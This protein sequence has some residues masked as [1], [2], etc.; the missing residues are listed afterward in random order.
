MRIWMCGQE[1]EQIRDWQLTDKDAEHGDVDEKKLVSVEDGDETSGRTS[2]DG[3]H[4][5]DD[6]AVDTRTIRRVYKTPCY[7]YPSMRWSD[8]L[9]TRPLR[10]AL[11]PS[12]SCKRTA[13]TDLRR[14]QQQLHH[15]AAILQVSLGQLLVSMEVFKDCITRMLLVL[16][17]QTACAIFWETF[18]ICSLDTVSQLSC[19]ISVTVFTMW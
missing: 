18:A 6:H 1:Q 7:R 16:V 17:E 14:Q 13:C 11:P 8:W 12:L 2:N 3:G 5:V 15:N 9:A 19:H 10:S 4:V